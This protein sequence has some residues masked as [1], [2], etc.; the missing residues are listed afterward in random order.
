MPRRR[1]DLLVG[2]W[3]VSNLPPIVDKTPAQVKATGG[4]GVAR[5]K[6]PVRRT[7]LPKAFRCTD[8]M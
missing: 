3:K 5:A 2:K 6:A 8:P 1:A 4:V 7:P